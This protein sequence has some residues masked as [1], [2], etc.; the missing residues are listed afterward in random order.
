MSKSDN[1]LQHFK[2][3]KGFV[4]KFFLKGFPKNK[5]PY[6][7]Q[8]LK[9]YKKNHYSEMK[10]CCCKTEFSSKTLNIAPQVTFMI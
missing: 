1:S 4:G 7:E 3:R 5:I 2:T 10:F 8:N 9:D 6:I